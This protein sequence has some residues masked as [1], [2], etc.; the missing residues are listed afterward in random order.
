MSNRDLAWRT[1]IGL[2]FQGVDISGEVQDRFVS[3]QYSDCVSGETDDLQ[4][5]LQDA[6]NKIIG[7]WLNTTLENRAAHNM[8]RQ[9]GA[10]EGVAGKTST[11]SAIIARVN[12]NRD[13][14]TDILDCGTFELDSVSQGGAPQTVT[15][16]GTSLDFSSGIRQTERCRVWENITL[17][18][19]AHRMAGS[20]GFSLMFL[21][22]RDPLYEWREQIQQSDIDFLEDLCE[23]AGI[24]I[25]V[26]NGQVVLFDT[27][28]FEKRPAVRTI[29][30][31]DRRYG[32]YRF[33]T[34]LARTAYSACTVSYTDPNTEETIKATFV[35]P[36]FVY[37]EDNVLRVN[38]EVSSQ[39]EAYELA[40]RRLREANKGETTA[41]LSGAG[42]TSLVSG[43]K[44]LFKEFGAF[45][46]EYLV[47]QST[48]AVDSS[49]G[50]R[51][52]L[53]LR[54]VIEGY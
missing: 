54:K 33:N 41:V 45:D 5:T 44:V 15:L 16:K 2:S 47:E 18:D 1:K 36:G 8:A 23:E 42:D 53:A 32:K 50:Y 31:G 52:S 10:G 19:I 17:R 4:I 11:F 13:G 30:L 27:A 48:H 7:E 9:S 40:Q 34:R 38:E 20:A 28:A 24:S 51:T 39:R 25:K 43:V 26:T 12:R 6:D 14:L 3:L 29:R 49:N 37:D 21:S 46:G 22:D 35:P